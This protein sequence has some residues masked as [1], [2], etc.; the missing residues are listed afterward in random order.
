MG[1]QKTPSASASKL[2]SPESTATLLAKVRQG[3]EAARNR[4]VCR[5]LPALRLWARGRTPTQV[6]SLVDTDDLVQMTFVGALGR[7]HEFDPHHNGAF[8]SYL[9]TILKNKIRDELRRVGR[10]PEM[11]ELSRSL[12]DN[13]P[14]PLDRVIWRETM[15][16]YDSAL[17]ELLDDQREALILRF[18]LGF[19]HAEV[20]E[21]IGD[22][23]PDAARALAA[24]ALHRIA[25]LMQK[26]A[27][28]RRPRP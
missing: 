24:R 20:A 5:Y 15:E 28:N 23:S 19:T 1:E 10:Q 18:E 17:E 16:I 13:G 22:I 3:D 12:P 11:L 21:A 14:S 6:R 26:R 8:I 27:A 2:R 4:L 7:L 25:G 9:R